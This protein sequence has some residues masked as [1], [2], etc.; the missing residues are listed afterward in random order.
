MGLHVSSVSDLPLSEERK[1]YLYVLD[2]YCWEEPINEALN[3]N[4]DRI[5]SFCAKNDAVMVRGL[6]DSHFASEVLSWQGING[7]DPEELLPAIMITTV[8][9]S[10]FIENSYSNHIQEIKDSLVFVKVRDVCKT[11]SDLVVFLEKMFADIKSEKKIKNF[12]ISQEIKAGESGS[13]VDTLILEPNISGL[14]VDLKALT[15]WF[16]S[17]LTKT[18]TPTR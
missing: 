14:G 1:Y 10:Y 15:T 5:A 17:R 3:K 8:H 9:P 7:I 11:P 6:P 4:M 16:K 2:Y 13:F 12:S 18:S